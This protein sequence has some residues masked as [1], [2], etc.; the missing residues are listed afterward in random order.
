MF[1]PLTSGE[2]TFAQ[3]VLAVAFLAALA[4]GGTC[5][6]QIATDADGFRD[7]R[8]AP[9]L[10]NSGEF[11]D[12]LLPFLQGHPENDEGNATI[13]LKMRKED[14]V[15]GV[16]I[17][18]TGYLDDSLAG[19]HFRGSVIRTREGEW[20]LL[21]M[22][23]KPLCARGRNIDG[24]CSDT[25]A[26]PVMFQTPGAAPSGPSMC[27]DIAAGDVLNVRQGPGTRFPATGTLAAGTCGVEVSN[28][29]EGNWCEIRS[30][31]ISGW[32]NTRYLEPYN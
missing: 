2:R 17:I 6:A 16:D 10:V 14:G 22:S 21:T 12:V 20:E 9:G 24:I 11:I 18:K 15:Y 26:P 1:H 23:V 32:M 7:I 3:K 5:Q 13:D 25:P 27:V 29:C 4:L 8:V 28:V 30:G 31:A 19:E